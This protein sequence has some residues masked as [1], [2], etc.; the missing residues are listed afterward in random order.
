MLNDW[1]LNIFL[2]SGGKKG[3]LSYYIIH[4]SNHQKLIKEKILSNCD[5]VI[6]IKHLCIFNHDNKVNLKWR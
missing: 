2:F 1:S 5:V 4:S 3:R 6:F